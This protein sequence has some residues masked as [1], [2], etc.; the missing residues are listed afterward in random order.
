MALDRARLFLD[1]CD[2]M[3]SSA[4]QVTPNLLMCE[5]VNNSKRAEP[6]AWLQQHLSNSG[7]PVTNAKRFLIIVC[8]RLTNCFEKFYNYIL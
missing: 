6:K 3:L 1:R 5:Q 7:V 2:M 8:L 4:S